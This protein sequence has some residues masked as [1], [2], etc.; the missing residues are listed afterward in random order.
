LSRLALSIRK[1]E[2]RAS[3]KIFLR[4]REVMPPRRYEIQIIHSRQHALANHR[5]MAIAIST[6]GIPNQ[7]E[8]PC[9]IRGS[10]P[11]RE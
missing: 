5:T 6:L 10:A 4:E 11:K 3:G 8:L 7:V 2:F 9:H 1:G